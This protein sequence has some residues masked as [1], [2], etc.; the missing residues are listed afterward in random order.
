M[1]SEDAKN[2]N[3]NATKNIESFFKNAEDFSPQNT[4]ADIEPFEESNLVD[5]IVASDIED[6]QEFVNDFENETSSVTVD[7]NNP[8]YEV[9]NRTA[10]VNRAKHSD[11]IVEDFEKIRQEQAEDEKKNKKETYYIAKQELE[12]LL[13]DNPGIKFYKKDSEGNIE[14]AAENENIDFEK[15]NLFTN[16]LEGIPEDELIGIAIPVGKKVEAPP[17]IEKIEE[18]ENNDS[19][20]PHIHHHNEYDGGDD[21]E[22]EEDVYYLP[23]EE[24]EE[25][26]QK[27]ELRERLKGVQSAIDA[28][29]E[30]I[31]YR[32]SDEIFAE[33]LQENFQDYLLAKKITGNNQVR[34]TDKVIDK[35]V[36]E[37]TH[38][39]VEITDLT[40]SDITTK[41]SILVNRDDDMEIESIEII[42]KCGEKTVIKFDEVEN[43]DAANVD[44]L[45]GAIIDPT[46][47]KIVI[48]SLSVAP[49]DYSIENEKLKAK[50]QETINEEIKE[51]FEFD[52]DEQEKNEDDDEDDDE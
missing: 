4:I 51:L 23:E 31:D 50:K 7:P 48:D 5:G 37:E 6:S 24:Q 43:F 41:T 25:K 32:T 18:N 30:K 16:D 10:I 44:D 46:N 42:C 38:K 20:Q 52:P 39:S 21:G 14:E 19:E 17:Q 13:A 35:D 40:H 1:D 2:N 45:N 33:F 8:F 28:M 11:F 34:F 12:H 3:L 47:T 22:S 9:F 29:T 36:V 49:L 27:E 15:L 26:R